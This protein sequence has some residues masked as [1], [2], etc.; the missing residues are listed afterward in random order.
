MLVCHD[1][2]FEADPVAPPLPSG[3][4]M[5]PILFYV[6][7]VGCAFFTAYFMIQRNAAERARL[8][9]ERITAEE[10]K[11]I[12]Q[13]QLKHTELEGDLTQAKSMI[14]WV[15]GSSPLQKLAMAINRKVADD[16]LTQDPYSLSKPSPRESMATPVQHSSE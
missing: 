7:I 11:K 12:A 8:A 15:K 13:I 5:I 6:A 4:R 3:L 14:D 9:Q 2:K 16:G 1:L 10:K